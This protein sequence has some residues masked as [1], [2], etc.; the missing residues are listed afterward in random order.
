MIKSYFTLARS[1]KKRITDLVNAKC[2]QS[3]NN[4]LLVQGNKTNE[5]LNSCFSKLFNDNKNKE[6]QVI[7]KS[8]LIVE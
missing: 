8:Q 4:Q 6:S 3:E 2:I 1:R 5:R 7:N